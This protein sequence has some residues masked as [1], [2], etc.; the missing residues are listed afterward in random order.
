MSDQEVESQ[1]VS[2]F[3]GVEDHSWRWTARQFVITFPG[4]SEREAR[5][6]HTL[7]LNVFVP[8]TQLRKLGP[9]TLTADVNGNILPS[10]T[11]R[12]AGPHSFIRTVPPQALESNIVPVVFFLDKS[13]GPLQ[14]EG[15]DLGLV[16]NSAQLSAN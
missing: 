3:Y 6:P 10:E 7:R 2:G 14:G 13:S 8:D 12:E 4:V 16:V 1:L 5:R 9:L 15:R 11:F